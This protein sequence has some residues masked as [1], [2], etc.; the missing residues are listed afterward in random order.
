MPLNGIKNERGSGG[1]HGH[2]HE[3]GH[4]QEYGQEAEGVDLGFDD[5]ELA[6]RQALD[7]LDAAEQQMGS[8]LDD[9]IESP[10]AVDDHS[11]DASHLVR[12]L[13]KN[14][15]RLLPLQRQRIRR[16]WLREFGELL[17]GK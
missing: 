10:T 5:L 9:L 13:T 8:V 17:R 2:G 12:D 1:E 16:C 11:A 15:S 4:E 7:A 14:C 6:Y 3:H